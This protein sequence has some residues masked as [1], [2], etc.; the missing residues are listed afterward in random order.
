[1]IPI[2]KKLIFSGILLILI[3]WVFLDDL[4]DD[5]GQVEGAPEK[6]QTFFTEDLLPPDW[7]VLEAEEW[8]DGSLHKPNGDICDENFELFVNR[9]NGLP[10]S[11]RRPIKSM[12]PSIGVSPLT[13]TPSISI[14]NAFAEFKFGNSRTPERRDS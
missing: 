9:R 3:A 5:W 14:R 11:R 1:M 13:R 4:V 8:S 7:S 2:N 6:L 12:A 10:L